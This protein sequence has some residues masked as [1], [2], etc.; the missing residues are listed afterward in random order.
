MSSD[1]P[2]TSAAPASSRLG[3]IGLSVWQYGRNAALSAAEYMTPVLAE[4]Q[5][6]SK[7]VL[8]PEEFV[9][10]GDMLVLRCP[11]WQWQAGD[12]SKARPFLPPG[13]QFLITRNVPCQR[14]A[15]TLSAGADDEEAVSL[16]GGDGD[17]EDWIATH[18]SH[19]AKAI[20]DDDVPDM[21]DA[22]PTTAAAASA[23]TA[24]AASSSNV[25]DSL[26]RLAVGSS[27]EGGTSSVEAGLEEACL[28]DDDPCALEEFD[29]V[30]EAAILRTRTYDVSITYDKYYQCARVWLYGY[31]EARQPLTQG[32]V[33]HAC[34]MPNRPAA[35][36]VEHDAQT[37]SARAALRPATARRTARARAK[38][39][40][41]HAVAGAPPLRRRC[42]RTSP[43]IMPSRP[44]LWR[45]IPTSAPVQDCTRPS[46]RASMPK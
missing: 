12:A 40:R 14:R 23:A 2:P 46:I 9:A 7:G 5:F 32:E 31:S 15:C 38:H 33:S 10:A 13:K 8:T 25:T 41:W 26:S 3:S 6:A 43:S 34:S 18:T 22:I 20:A 17:E 36:A 44:S 27:G 19:A 35:H 1:P 11:T 4:S 42:S 37:T 45:P 24:K 39:R 30:A 21:T 28:E 16:G 29:D